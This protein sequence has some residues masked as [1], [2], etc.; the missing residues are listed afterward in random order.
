M[1]TDKGTAQDPLTAA[2]A[3]TDAPTDAQ[4][5]QAES[6]ISELLQQIRAQ[7]ASPE[8][9]AEA[10]PAVVE[11]DYAQ[12]WQAMADGDMLRATDLFGELAL[13]APDQF[14]VQFGF[15]LCLQHAGLVEDAGRHF[16]LAY[17]LDPSSAACAFRLGEC[18][19]TAGH[20]DDAREAFLTAIEL[21]DVPDTDQEIRA[22]AQ[23]ALD[24]MS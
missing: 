4:W 7:A 10:D 21:C 16:G 22:Y 23:D 14:R 11:R 19:L 18:L 6:M 15:G 9:A 5:A 8:E 17:V 3:P 1:N 2:D 20:R 12:A 24:R 13:R